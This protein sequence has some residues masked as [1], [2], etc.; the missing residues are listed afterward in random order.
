[1]AGYDLVTEGFAEGQVGSSAMP[2]KMNTRSSER[3]CS[4]TQVLK[5][6][7]D[8]ASRIAGSQWEE[9]DVSCSAAR[10]VFIPG[11]FYA[12]DGIC[13]TTLTILN[14]MGAYPAV[15]GAEVDR[16][17]PYLATTTILGLATKKGIGRETAHKIIREHS[18]KEALAMR[19]K[20][21]TQ[22]N[23]AARLSEDPTFAKAGI[24]KDEINGILKERE[25][26]IGDA[27][28]QINRVYQAAN[29]ASGLISRYGAESLY[30]PQPIL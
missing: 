16:F 4:L 21:S 10:R 15:I 28:G 8:M 29:K 27:K 22:N 6:Y 7:Q 14:E 11:S 13:E 25:K 24:T 20:G 23:L 12:S 30:E 1:M 3:V 18:I 19:Q 17:L 26:F 9:G 5:G 2:H